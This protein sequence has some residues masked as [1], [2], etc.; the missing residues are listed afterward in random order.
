MTP[1]A[2]ILAPMSPHVIGSVTPFDG[3]TRSLKSDDIGDVLMV[4]AAIGASVFVTELT[5]GLAFC[6]GDRN[7]GTMSVHTTAKSTNPLKT[8]R[9]YSLRCEPVQVSHGD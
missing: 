3:S 5:L 9:Q 2:I 1:D 7:A 8:P 4:A 6:R